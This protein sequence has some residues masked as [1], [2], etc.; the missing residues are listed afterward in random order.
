MITIFSNRELPNGKVRR[1][2]E[3]TVTDL[4][5]DTHTQI[6][7]LFDHDP[8]DTGTQVETDF[9]AGKKQQEIDSYKDTI[10]AGVNP[11]LNDSL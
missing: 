11:F 3:V 10:R 4:L 1:R 7:G 2:Y 8:S 9:L 5:G 6:I